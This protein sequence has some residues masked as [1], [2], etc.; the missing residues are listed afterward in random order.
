MRVTPDNTADFLTDL[1]QIQSAQRTA[2]REVSTGRRVNLP[3]D[4]PAAAA[5]NVQNQAA[6]DRVDQYL[7]STNRLQGE[8]QTADSALG[9]AVSSLTQAISLGIEGA[10]SNLPAADQQAI[11]QAVEGIRDNLIQL[12]NA[13]YQ[14][15]YIF[16]GTANGSA[17]YRVDP[18]QPSGV[19]YQGNSGVNAVQVADGR[20]VQVN[21][22]G[23]QLFQGT[24][25]DVFASL[26]QL[27][28]AL[29]SGNT[30]NIG[31]ATSQIRTALDH[32]SAQ[33]VFYGNTINQLTSNQTFLQQEKVSLQSEQNNL[34][35]IDLAKAATDLAQ[36]QTANSATLAAFARVIP[37][38]LLDFLK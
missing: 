5:A 25:S 22:P 12:A 16:G 37:Q 3:S 14:G 31:T 26:Q 17:P 11:A 6:Q 21:I 15:T 35:G 7:Q 13:S 19:L 29:Q 1:F 28:T 10:N 4:D 9:S 20:S 34:V 27:I 32:L 38:S 8:L 2:L 18:T 24:G 36:A 30:A 33:R 23:D